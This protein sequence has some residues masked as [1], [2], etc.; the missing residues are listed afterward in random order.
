MFG[1]SSHLR[2]LLLTFPEWHRRSRHIDT[3]TVRP[4]NRE[5]LLDVVEL[6]RGP[7]AIAR[8]VSH[9]LA[10]NR[11]ADLLDACTAQSLAMFPLAIARKICQKNIK[12]ASWGAAFCVP[13]ANL[14]ICKGLC[15]V[16]GLDPTAPSLASRFGSGRKK[17]QVPAYRASSWN[18]RRSAR[19]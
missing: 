18:P 9:S 6:V 15:L 11:I 10:I 19:G 2:F 12:A 13:L 17:N 7:V 1:S 14:L 8:E 16:A 3:K 5:R 4:K